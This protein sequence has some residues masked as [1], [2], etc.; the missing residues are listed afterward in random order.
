MA[1]QI[2]RV[3]PGASGDDKPYFKRY[4]WPVYQPGGADSA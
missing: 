2:N 1:A 4:K 3:F